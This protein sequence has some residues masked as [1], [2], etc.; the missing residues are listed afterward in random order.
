M[1]ASIGICRDKA[2]YPDKERHME[3]INEPLQR[4]VP[5]GT[6]LNGAG[7]EVTYYHK[8]Y[9]EALRSINVL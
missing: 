2:R 7:R 4:V 8:D 6:R 9:R 1:H 5:F 3:L